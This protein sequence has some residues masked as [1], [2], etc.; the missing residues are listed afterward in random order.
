M[1]MLDKLKSLV[2][3]HEDTARQ[4]VEKVG[5]AVDT[6]TQGKYSRHVDTAQQKLNDQIGGAQRP[7][8]EGNPPPA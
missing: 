4:G 3:G 5:D 7:P 6:R 8:D 1:S 2:K